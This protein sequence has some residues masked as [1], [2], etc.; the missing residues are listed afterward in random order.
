M[1]RMYRKS[2]NIGE[3]FGVSSSNIGTRQDRYIS[4]G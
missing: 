1:G 3:Q 2:I 4:E